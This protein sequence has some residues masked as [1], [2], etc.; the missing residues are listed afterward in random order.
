MSN[1][2]EIRLS[3]DEYRAQPIPFLNSDGSKPKIASFYVGVSDLPAELGDW[4]RVNPRVPTFKATK[5]ELKGPVA[6]AIVRTLMERP[7]MMCL[8]NNG[9]TIVADHVEFNKGT[10]GKGE[11][12]IRLTDPENHGVANGGHTLAAIFQVGD[13]PEHPQ[14]WDASVRV[15]VYEGLEKAVIPEMA[16]GLNRSLQVDDK[17]LRN[18]EGTFNKIKHAL[19]GKTG[20]DMIAY[21]QGDVQPVDVHFVLALLALL[22]VDAYPSHKSHPNKVFGQPGLVLKKFADDQADDGP[23]VFDRLIPHVHDILVLSDRIQK[24]GVKHLGRLKVTNSK[25]DNRVASEKHKDRDAYF[26]GG[27]IEGFFAL[28]WLYPVVAAFRVNIDRA[29]WDQGRLEWR[30]PPLELLDDTIEEM[31]QVIRQEHTDNKDKPA[32]VGKKDAAYRGCY[33]EIMMELAHRGLLTP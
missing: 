10:G 21:R 16:Q 14:P 19:A 26:D 32:E 30:V 3:A 27:K 18:L 8:M 33:G 25:K 24:L 4:M 7:E 15:L 2:L 23:K 29:A 17:S 1:T 5:P 12:T 6:G 13:D 9:I 22:N 31:C 11:V 28:G 20:S